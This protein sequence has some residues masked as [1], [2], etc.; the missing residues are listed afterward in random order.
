[1]HIGEHMEPLLAG[2][3]A[4]DPSDGAATAI[5][6][7]HIC[8]YIHRE[9]ERERETSMNPHIYIWLYSYIAI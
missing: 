4:R 1:M 3:R 2:E 7:I 9:R 5:T 6:D 8:I